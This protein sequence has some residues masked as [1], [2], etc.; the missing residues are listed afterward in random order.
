VPKVNVYLPDDLAEDARAAKLSLSPICQAAIREE[1][2]RMNAVKAASRD[3]K[4]VASRLNATIADD[5]RQQAREGRA[6]GIVWA[7]KYATAADLRFIA[8]DFEPGGGWT[9]DLDTFPSICAFAGDRDRENVISV[10]HEDTP[11]WRGF[12]EGAS[13]ILKAVEPLLNS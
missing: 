5:V 10:G 12:I 4:A 9:F 2:D 6:N 13:E 1:L 8:R 3:I 11:Y 7:R